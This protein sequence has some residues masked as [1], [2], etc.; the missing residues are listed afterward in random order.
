VK[1]G[2][3]GI[4][5]GYY[6]KSFSNVLEIR[7]LLALK[8]RK[9]YDWAVN[10]RSL[11]TMID[12][13]ENLKMEMDKGVRKSIRLM[14]DKGSWNLGGDQTTEDVFP[15]IWLA[16]AY[17]HRERVKRFR[18][19]YEELFELLGDRAGRA[20]CYRRHFFFLDA[21]KA[22]HELK[23]FLKFAE[24]YMH[25]FVGV[26]T[27]KSRK[28]FSGREVRE[29]L[30]AYHLFYHVVK[31]IRMFWKGP[32][33]GTTYDGLK[34]KFPMVDSDVLKEVIL[35]PE[36][37]RGWRTKASDLAL[38]L[39]AEHIGTTQKNVKRILKEEK[40]YRKTVEELIGGIPEPEK[41]LAHEDT[42][43]DLW[44]E[45]PKRQSDED[46]IRMIRTL[47]LPED[48]STEKKAP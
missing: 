9:V 35:E 28:T 22:T 46:R 14:K 31:R 37:G 48:L 3:E 42:I 16:A 39:T 19:K 2:F 12:E 20:P 45:V 36:V 29:C 13:M 7:I 6:R 8:G 1:G 26:E 38:R 18:L 25:I 10:V 34:K 47:F 15:D 24:L 40:R 5:K 21:C 32:G 33:L 27:A 17:R 30:I 43:P 4:G 44:P 23:L 41:I 11:E